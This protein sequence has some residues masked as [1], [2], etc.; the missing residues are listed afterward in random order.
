[1]KG[2]IVNAYK[3]F[4]NGILKFLQTL[5]YQKAKNPKKVLVFRTGSFGDSIAAMPAIHGIRRHYP[6]AQL[7]LLSNAGRKNLVSPAN[8]IAPN[9]FD[10]IID[11]HGWDRNQ[12]TERLKSEAFDL[13]IQLPQNKAPFKSLLRDLIYFRFLVGIRSG[14]GWRKEFVPFFRAY[15]DD[16]IEQISETQRLIDICKQHGI[17]IQDRAY[18]FNITEDDKHAFN[19]LK[20]TH[21]LRQYV[22]IIVG[23]KRPQNR[24]PLPYF[25]AV[26][27]VLS[28]H[29]QIV[30][31]GGPEDSALVAQLENQT[32]FIDL[33]G[34]TSPVLSGLVLQEAE[35]VITNDTG[36]MHMA[37]AMET[38]V[39]ALFSSRDYKNIWFPPKQ[40]T[41]FRTNDI[42]CKLCLSETCSDN[43]CMQAITPDQ[44]LEAAKEKLKLEQ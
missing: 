1:M 18:H 3:A 25:D 8:L 33:T 6:D 4:T 42:D 15:Q 34:K 24:W 31:V 29:H 35:L 37:Y 21:Q 10:E 14:W 12:V 13:V 11:Y 9:V 27:G 41:V 40:H 19:Q 16:H 2:L 7:T 36:P 22:A 32:S 38:P 17:S 39:I 30:I 28:N 43:K 44:V 20:S 23:G 5:V 26:I